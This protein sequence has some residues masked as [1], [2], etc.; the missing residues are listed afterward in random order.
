MLRV[1]CSCGK[2][3]KVNEDLAGKK[4][5][6][7]ECAT[8]LTVKAAASAAVS[9]RPLKPSTRDEDDDEAVASGPPKKKPTAGANGPSAPV[10]KKPAANDDEDELPRPK[11][12]YRDEDLDDED[13][14]P[15][16]KKAEKK[17]SGLLIVALLGVAAVLFVVLAGAG[18]GAYFL[19]FKKD[20]DKGGDSAGNSG[21][22]QAGPGSK[23]EPVAVKLHVPLKVGDVREMKGTKDTTLKVTGNGAQQTFTGKITFDLKV[24]TLAVN[25]QGC[26]TRGEI[27]FNSLTVVHPDLFGGAPTT[28]TLA[29]SVVVL[30]ESSGFGDNPAKFVNYRVKDPKQN[31]FKEEGDAQ[32]AAMDIFGNEMPMQGMTLED[33]YG[34]SEKKAV[35]DSWSIKKAAAT[36][37]LTADLHFIIAK[38]KCPVHKEED[39]TGSIK[40]ESAPKE[41]NKQFIEFKT[42]VKIAA[43]NAWNDF[44][45]GPGLGGGGKVKGENLT[46]AD[47]Q[48]KQTLR[49]PQD[50]STG[51]VKVV[52]TVVSSW[53]AD[54]KQ[55]KGA[56]EENDTLDMDIKYLPNEGGD[57]GGKEPDSKGPLKLTLVSATATRSSI[58]NNLVDVEV[59]YNLTGEQPKGVY[60]LQFKAEGVD[61]SGKA[62]L[63]NLL[64]GDP[65]GQLKMGE[66]TIKGSINVSPNDTAVNLTVMGGF[67]AENKLASME[68]IEIK[69]ANKG[70]PIGDSLKVNIVG[71]PQIKWVDGKKV[72]VDLTY[73]SSGKTD[74]KGDIWFYVVFKGK[75]GKQVFQT[76]AQLNPNTLKPSESFSKELT[77]DPAN[78]QN[79]DS[80]EIVVVQEGVKGNLAPNTKVSVSGTTTPTPSNVTVQLTNPKVELISG[81]KLRVTVNWAAASGSLDQNGN[82]RLLIDPK[83][84]GKFPST[85]YTGRGSDFQGQN[86][87]IKEVAN[88]QQLAV[89]A[90]YELT[91]VELSAQ[92]PQGKVISTAAAQ[93]N[94]VADA[95]ASNQPLKINAAAAGTYTIA[96]NKK[97]I[98]IQATVQY[99]IVSGQPKPG[100]S[101][102]CVAILLVNGM[103][104]PIQI[105]QYNANDFKNNTGFQLGNSGQITGNVTAATFLIVEMVPGQQ[106]N[107]LA[108]GQLQLLLKK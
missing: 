49:F 39:I 10:K 8:V 14:R 82:Y 97:G 64:P 77:F 104:V 48:C 15:R 96:S 27:T 23:G 18:V 44:T 102:K 37:A 25:A 83:A 30:Q 79:T 98:H 31:N 87:I 78:L 74:A 3:L 81:N 63:P 67:A 6:C 11:K 41:G 4:I 51:P 90:N 32:R 12:K 68:K 86:P 33:L 80:A 62:G 26:Q 17:G 58:N 95:S 43:L 69:A 45:K 60:V 50:Y 47:Y 61:P 99:Q 88:A 92:A 101:Y 35:G 70:G 36:K 84:P 2:V 93:G 40:V 42:D 55:G 107:Q 13:E 9:T 105:G 28:R 46:A 38:I 52:E 59:R 108:G 100:A 85:V 7:P 73:T 76:L 57:A 1:A 103:Q 94:V 75:D 65:P 19:F 20:S 91:F 21:T 56:C 54:T 22:P 29:G 16:K 72:K 66:Q 106:D 89:G 5:K 24:K 53:S 34:T 71:T